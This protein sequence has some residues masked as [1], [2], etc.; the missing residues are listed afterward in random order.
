MAL[1]AVVL[2]TDDVIYVPS[3][4]Y[5]QQLVAKG[6]DSKK[7]RLFPH[8]ADAEV[9]HPRYRDL[10]WWQRFGVNGGPKILYVGR[11][12]REKDLDVLV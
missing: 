9:F 11:I 7:L 1:L 8:G 2:R 5:K 6:F 10:Q 3:R 12:A 4:V